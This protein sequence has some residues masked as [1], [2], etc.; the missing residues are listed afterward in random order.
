MRPGKPVPEVEDVLALLDT[1]VWHWDATDG[2]LRLDAESARLLGMPARA[3]EVPPSRVR[4]LLHPAD[5]NELA[6]VIRLAA[7]ENALAE[8]RL[9]V[10][11]DLGHP[12]RVLRVRCGRPDPLAEPRRLAGTVQ[13]VAEPEPGIRAGR[14]VTG[15]RRRAREAFLLDAG[16]SLAQAES[17]RDVLRVAA[18][19]SMPGFSPSGLAV[20]RPD[21][22][23]LTV[24]GQR[25]HPS[26]EGTPFDRVG[27][28][29]DC[30]PAEVI[31]T[32]RAVYLSSGEDFRARYPHAW[33]LVEPFGQRSWAFL[34]LS[35]A[36]RPTG[37]WMASFSCTVA[38]TP[39]ERSVLNTVARML[40]QALS[41]AGAADT[42][43]DFT[44]VLQ[45]SVLPASGPEIP[46][47]TVA[48]RYVPTGGGLG[49]GGDWFDVIP[50][51]LGRF[52]LVIGDVQGH[53]GRAAGL[54]GQVRVALR[55]Y[56][57]E[58][59]RPDTVLARASRFFRDLADIE[60][61]PRFATCFYAEVDPTTG[62]VESARAGHLDPVVR[63]ADGT[64]MIRATPG[65]LP[66]GIAS[67]DDFP[68]TRLALEPGDTL[69][70]CT[71]G[72]V[73]TGGH[74]LFSGWDRLRPVLEDATGDLEDLADALVDAVHGPSSHRT[75]GPL[76]ERREDDSALLLLRRDQPAD[77][78]RDTTE[79]TSMRRTT[80]SVAQTEPERVATARA[81]LTDLLHD[82]PSDDQRDAAVLLLSETLTNV[83]LHTDTDALLVAEVTGEPGERRIRIEVRDDADA[84]PHRR[85]PGEMSS[86]GRG[87]LLIEM[88]AD[89][90]GVS[91]RGRGK[92]VWFE[93]YEGSGPGSGPTASPPVPAPGDG[94]D[95]G[96]GAGSGAA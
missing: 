26:A 77:E 29:A 33:P 63:M 4:A 24:V 93:F 14:A 16:L 27:R 20:F 70:L 65:G 53:D 6:E 23:R 94:P 36:G 1:G 92:S 83:L 79:R 34:P 56:A 32:G 44:E 28:D 17:T 25:G 73:E 76:A 54:M 3:A 46:G 58:G 67:D 66:L 41:R 11:D 87:L 51:P 43:R 75:V 39:D 95:F 31:R 15:D 86:S 68:L 37:A 84:L 55:A 48:A 2:R 30:P 62:T 91:P 69:M 35:V 96:S 72:L 21:G 60:D 80:L 38:F 81:H 89:T 85:R 71:D 8:S 57:A 13:Q 47:M 74:D 18:G 19:L 61:D 59:H 45:R 42:R 7:A 5:W 9:R 10:L 78:A 40:A 82:W 12:V 90:W 50:L 49:V 88:L 64:S 52:A 22:E